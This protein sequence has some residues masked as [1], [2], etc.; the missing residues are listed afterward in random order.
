MIVETERYWDSACGIT[1][2]FRKNPKWF[3]RHCSWTTAQA[4][5]FITGGNFR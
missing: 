3:C 1:H 4:K 5:Q 2:V